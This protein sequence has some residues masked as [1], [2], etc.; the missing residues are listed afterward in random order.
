MILLAAFKPHGKNRRCF[1]K[2]MRIMKLTAI[3]LIA[4][5]LQVGARGIAQ[6]VTINEKDVPL[7]KV[8]DVLRKQTSYSFLYTREMLGHTKRVSL[9]FKNATIEQVMDESLRKQP[10]TYTIIKKTIVLKPKD[11]ETLQIEST[12]VQ[13]IAR[14]ITGRV[15]DQT[16]APVMATVMVKGTNKGTSTN[17]NGEFELKGVEDETILVISGVSIETKEVKVGGNT[18]FNIIVNKKIQ[19]AGEVMITGYQALESRRSAGAFGFIGS[20]KLESRPTVDLTSALEGMVSGLRVYDEGGSSRLDVRGIG[21][22]TLSVSSPLIV[23]DGFPVGN[24]FSGVNPNDVQSIHVLKDAAATSV[25]GARAS[26]G[27]IVITTKKAKR[28]FH[29]NVNSFVGI[30]EKPDIDQ[31]NPI[32][33]AASAIEWEKYLWENGQMFSSFT[34]SSSVD[35]NNNPASMAV[36]LLN[37]RDQGRISASEFEQEWNQLKQ[38]N[39]Q[40]DV[41]KYLLQR[42]FTQNYDVTLSGATD[43]NN[44]VF[45]T[46]YVGSKSQFQYDNNKSFLTNLR[47]NYQVTKWLDADIALMARFE[48]S[49][50]S[51]ASLEEIKSMSPYETL[52][53]ANG[54]YSRMVG[55]HYQEFID[56]TG[57]YFNQDWNYNLLQEARSRQIKSD[58]N[59]IRLQFGLNFKLLKGLN[60]QS[61]FQFEQ[62]KTENSNYYSPESYYVRDQLNKWVDFDEPNHKVLK[63][64][65]PD[66]GQYMRS[67]GS[68]QSYNFRNQLSYQKVIKEHEIT[69]GLITEVYS[70]IYENY[71]A[72]VIYGY[73]PDKLT[74]AVPQSYM[75]KSYWGG[76]NYQLTGMNSEMTYKNDRFFSLLGNLAYTY[77]SKYTLSGSFRTDA[78]NLIVDDPKKRYSPFWSIGVNWKADR[79]D[80]IAAWNNLNRL[81]FRFSYGETGNVVLSTSVVPLIS[82]FGVYPLTGAPYASVTDYGN[83]TL[84]WER[85][86]TLNFGVD[87]S[88]FQD[89]LFGSLEVYNKHGRDI[90]GAIDLPRLTG[91]TT[92]SFNTAEIVNKG[93][94]VSVGT[95]LPLG[96]NIGFS[97]NLNFSYNISKVLNLLHINY[98]YF[99]IRSPHF[100]EGKPVDAIYS[101]TYL[102]MDANNNPILQGIGHTSFTFNDVPP[103]TADDR[104]YMQ[105]SGSA[106]PTTVIGWQNSLSA[107]GFSLY[108]IV[109]GEFGHVFRRP[110]FDYPI[111]ANSKSS[112]TIHR[113]VTK[114]LDNSADDIPK[115]PNGN[116]LNLGAW[117]GYAQFLNT[118]IEPAD[119][120]RLKEI[121]LSYNLSQRILSRIGFTTGRIYMQ[122]RDPNLV[123]VKN[124][125]GLDPMYIYNSR[126]SAS[127]AAVTYL[128]P[129][130]S[131]KLGVSF[132]F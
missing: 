31:F 70:K 5:C 84:T 125:E 64:Y 45:N 101:Y 120:L 128:R 131:Y 52:V 23:V 107:C 103:V 113:D 91:T 90:V 57:R 34:L 38:R 46:R 117:G 21:T 86:A 98:D 119:A 7:E 69:A 15:L 112:S 94:E 67:Y 97:S 3:L 129:T 92:Q 81:N 83:P 115:M 111:L 48:R 4:G 108:V 11:P 33:D 41:N 39:Y 96:K 44:F 114:V 85:T 17:E 76:S 43:R 10:L 25:W 93:F 1:S 60:Y 20:E 75:V 65:V 29:V 73:D 79:E 62:Y 116:V 100:E 89:K 19:N 68:F 82:V 47:N 12:L 109:T 18:D 51:G 55:A 35:G 77:K 66:G 122:L 28:G 88:F 16:G 59:D 121:N 71:N 74:S 102:G 80:F 9:Q 42:A 78:S 63:S 87:Y 50:S 6:N 110:T 37:L 130:T 13:K 56:S 58:Q 126:A 24:A 14:D 53:D 95:K 72:P 2:I 27:V 99:A 124:K 118:T 106:Q 32:A 61:R 22:M 30:Q 40:S 127:A 36:T 132:G 49:N 104:N 8:F 123:W 54:Q 26:N 105:Y